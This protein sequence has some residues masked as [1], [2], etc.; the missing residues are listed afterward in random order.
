MFAFAKTLDVKNPSASGRQ[1]LANMSE[2]KRSKQTQDAE[3]PAEIP[4]TSFAT[5]ATWRR[6]KG[7]AKGA[8][9]VALRL[10]LVLEKM[11]GMGDFFG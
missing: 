11:A 9:A 2:T 10:P 4:T 5:G 6:A 7:S 1:T 3:A 8:S